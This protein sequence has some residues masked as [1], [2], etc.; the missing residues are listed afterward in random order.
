MR[1]WWLE[2]LLVSVGLGLGASILAGSMTY[3]RAAERAVDTLARHPDYTGIVVQVRQADMNQL[4]Q[5]DGPPIVPL[6]ASAPDDGQR[7][8][9]ELARELRDRVAGLE[10]VLL[11]SMPRTFSDTLRAVDGRP[12]QGRP[13]RLSVMPVGPDYFAAYDVRFA[14]GQGFTWTDLTEGRSVLVLDESWA[15]QA[16]QDVPPSELVG[17]TVMAFGRNWTVAG[18]VRLPRTDGLAATSAF[19]PGG[20]GGWVPW[21]SVMGIDAEELDGL[22]FVP[23]PEADPEALRRSL[24]VELGGR[25]DA[26]LLS[27]SGP[28]DPLQ[29]TGTPL[30]AAAAGV[31]SLALLV[32]SMTAL[33]LFLTR[34]RRRRRSLALSAALGASRP[35]VFLEMLVDALLLGVAGGLLGAVG[36]YA[37]LRVSGSFLVKALPLLGSHEGLGFTMET[38]AWAIGAGVA[39]SLV[40]GLYPAYEAATQEVAQS[41]RGGAAAPGKK[42]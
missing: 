20:L 2:S 34:A 32:A 13:G 6:V 39:A 17:H 35:V 29:S 26:G 11:G 25:F 18:V 38:L 33:N 31:A 16:V 10:G 30:V 8:T 9:V 4:F 23:S 37:A 22:R 42:G 41:L 19:L 5:P 1:A 24:E 15:R 28:K 40:V 12:G 7:V 36:A 3:L 21:G 27:F 14:A